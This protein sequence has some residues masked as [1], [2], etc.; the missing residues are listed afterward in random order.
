MQINKFLFFSA[1]FLFVLTDA[2]QAQG[3]KSSPLSSIQ[4]QKEAHDQEEASEYLI[5]VSDILEITVLQPQQLRNIVTVAPDG[6]VTFPYIGSVPAKDRT[7]TEVQEDIQK[8]LADGYMKYPVVAVS[9]KESR[10]QKF[11]VYGEVMEPGA[12]PLEEDMTVLGAISMAGGLSEFGSSSRVKILRPK[13]NAPGYEV[14]KVNI[15]AL[16]NG[17]PK[18]D[19]TVDPGDIIIVSEGIF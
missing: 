18:A 14:I 12:F 5:G 16:M 13:K 1:V 7:L 2:G 17:H 15:K 4:R 3:V 6:R 11:F 9:L 10:S 19:I 8:R